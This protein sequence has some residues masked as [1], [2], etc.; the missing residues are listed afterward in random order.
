MGQTPLAADAAGH[1]GPMT[2]NLNRLWRRQAADRRALPVYAPTHQGGRLGSVWDP[3]TVDGTT[4]ELDREKLRALLDDEGI[5]PRSYRRDG[6]HPSE[7][8]ALDRRG[9]QWGTYYSERGLE[10][11][12]AF[13]ASEDGACQ[14]LRDLLLRDSSTRL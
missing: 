8:Y 12:L 10:S 6:G 9:D 14:C 1:M 3:E 4:D 2:L 7:A 11:G 13:F 5:D